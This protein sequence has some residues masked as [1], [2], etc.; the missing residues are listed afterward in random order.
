MV[1]R[2]CSWQ[3]HHGDAVSIVCQQTKCQLVFCLSVYNRHVVRNFARWHWKTCHI[4]SQ[5]A[6]AAWKH[7][8]TYKSLDWVTCYPL[9]FTLACIVYG[10]SRTLQVVYIHVHYGVHGEMNIGINIGLRRMRR[11]FSWSRYWADC[12][13]NAATE[14]GCPPSWKIAG[15]GLCKIRHVWTVLTYCKNLPGTNIYSLYSSCL[16]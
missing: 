2:R 8:S 10:E 9:H 4:S 14:S 12:P 6:W 15:S 11:Q 13:L 1:H 5:D 7:G 16:S 3:I